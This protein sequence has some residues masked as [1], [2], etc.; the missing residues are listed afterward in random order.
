MVA[1]STGEGFETAINMI[2][3]YGYSRSGWEN[4]IQNPR[5]MGDVNGDGMADIVAMS[6]DKIYVSFS[7][8]RIR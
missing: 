2:D 4:M 8:G 5:M 7:N 1:F 6:T 3:D